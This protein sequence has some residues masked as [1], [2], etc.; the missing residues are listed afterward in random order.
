MEVRHGTRTVP[1]GGTKQRALLADLI[2]NAGRVVPA[3]KLI[4]DLW[5]DDP[6]VTAAHTLET[7]VSRIRQ[8]LRGAAI[9]GLQTRPPGYVLIAEPEDVDALRFEALV[10]AADTAMGRLETEDAAELLGSALAL[11]R[12]P[13][14]ADVLDMPFIAASARRLEDLRLVALEKRIDADLRA[15]RHRELVSE[16]ESLTAADPYREPFH[17]QLILALYRS[18]RQAESLAAYRRARDVLADQLG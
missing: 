16:L 4:D 7:Y 18:G 3:S 8:A 13:A 14:L 9:E 1:L 5:G 11:W 2:L 15:G 12:G 10:A 6:P 17:K